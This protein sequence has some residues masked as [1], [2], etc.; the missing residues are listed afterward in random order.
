MKTLTTL[1]L[2]TLVTIGA[3]SARAGGACCP[4]SAA[5]GKD[6][7]K[8]TVTATATATCEVAD[9]FAKL[10]LSEDQKQK[11]AALRTECKAG[12]C[13]ESASKKY[14]AGLKEILSADQLKQLGDAGC[15]GVKAEAKPVGASATEIPK[16]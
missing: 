2:I 4:A 1:T 10:N 14:N 8:A 11:L 16:H 13:T 5:K 6:G 3:A 7:A 9:P 12:K 15:G